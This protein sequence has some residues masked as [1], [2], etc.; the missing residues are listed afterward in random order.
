MDITSIWYHTIVL[1]LLTVGLN[2]IPPTGC[3]FLLHMQVC[4][5]F[6]F[7]D[8]NVN[9]TKIGLWMISWIL[10]LYY[11]HR[12]WRF[13]LSMK[14][15]GIKH[16]T[17]IF[18]PPDWIWHWHHRCTAANKWDKQVQYLCTDR[19][20]VGISTPYWTRRCCICPLLLITEMNSYQ[21]HG[22]R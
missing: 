14:Q 22:V 20:I 9:L 12:C 5:W 8:V 1:I 2:V 17:V 11:L 15:F 6:I 19:S 10:Q 4:K 3:D 21:E 18:H 13:F 16:S 7:L